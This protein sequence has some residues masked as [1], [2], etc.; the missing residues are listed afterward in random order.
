MRARIHCARDSAPSPGES[1]AQPYKRHLPQQRRPARGDA[2]ALNECRQVDTVVRVRFPI[3]SIN[4]RRVVAGAQPPCSL[5]MG[6]LPLEG[7]ARRLLAETWR[8]G[9]R[10]VGSRFC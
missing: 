5:G 6:S 10:C 3:S 9:L 1:L 8:G 7:G 2:N 4:G